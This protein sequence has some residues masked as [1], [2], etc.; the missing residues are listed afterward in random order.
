MTGNL[1]NT[2][3][4][5]GDLYLDLDK[6]VVLSAVYWILIRHLC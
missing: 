5:S 4:E 1:G 2:S 3:T 6:V